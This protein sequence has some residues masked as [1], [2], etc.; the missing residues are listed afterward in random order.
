MYHLSSDW[1]VKYAT[2]WYLKDHL[3]PS[4]S[5]TFVINGIADN[6]V[7]EISGVVIDNGMAETGRIYNLNGQYMGDNAS[8]DNLPKGLYIMNGKKFIV[9]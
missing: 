1:G 6:T 4:M 9:R 8:K 3:N 7:T 2:M 5:R